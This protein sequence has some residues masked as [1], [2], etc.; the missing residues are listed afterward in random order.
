MPLLSFQFLYN[1][2]DQNS[3]SPMTFKALFNTV[4]RF[5]DPIAGGAAV[6]S[7]IVRDTTTIAV[8]FSLTSQCNASPITCSPIFC[9]R[10]RAFDVN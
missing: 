6:D 3:E 1:Q 9:L 7:D 2:S 8:P 4:C 5:Y 10:C